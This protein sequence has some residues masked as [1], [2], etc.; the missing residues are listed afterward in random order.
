M[1]KELKMLIL[2]QKQGGT[3]SHP[4]ATHLGAE[5]AVLCA[6]CCVLWWAEQG[7]EGRSLP[8]RIWAS[9]KGSPFC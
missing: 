6:V 1:V 3:W 9:A 8:D 7:Q 2:E 5:E 4:V